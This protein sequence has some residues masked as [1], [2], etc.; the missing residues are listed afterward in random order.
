MD[1]SKFDEYVTYCQ[2]MA[3]AQ[4]A[5]VDSANAYIARN[6]EQLVT[7]NKEY[8]DAK[9]KATE[10][11]DGWEKQLADIVDDAFFERRSSDVDGF[12][13]DLKERDVLYKSILTYLE[14]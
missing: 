11:S 10:I 3:D 1:S 6:K 8:N 5:A 2:L 9:E 12:N 7:K 13:Q 14:G 4:D